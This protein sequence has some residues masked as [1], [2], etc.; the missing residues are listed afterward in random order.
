MTY[1]L[2]HDP[3]FEARFTASITAAQVNVPAAAMRCLDPACG[4]KGF[5]Q[6]VWPYDR[7]RCRSC[8]RYVVLD[9]ACSGSRVR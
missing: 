4:E 1:P 8:G 9:N 5:L 2:G 6:V 7:R 3:A